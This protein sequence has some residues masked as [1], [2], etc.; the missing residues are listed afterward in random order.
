MIFTFIKC[1]VINLVILLTCIRTGSGFIKFWGSGSTSL[2]LT[3]KNNLK[4][5]FL[6]FE[7]FYNID[8]SLER[9]RFILQNQLFYI[10]M[11][12]SWSDSCFLVNKINTEEHELS[13]PHRTPFYDILCTVDLSAFI[14]NGG[15]LKK[16]EPFVKKSS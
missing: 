11:L 3:K 1:F 14:C 8:R 6:G 4:N 2:L 13:E 15:A 10:Y 5:V 9:N 16:T 12:D 7:L